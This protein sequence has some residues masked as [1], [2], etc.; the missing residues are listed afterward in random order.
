MLAGQACIVANALV[1]LV[2]AV[3]GDGQPRADVLSREDC[4]AVDLLVCLAMAGA[5][6]LAGGPRVGHP[7]DALTSA[8]ALAGRT[9]VCG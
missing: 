4:A 5:K 1:E 6:V 9:M 3:A 7:Y 2:L 8:T